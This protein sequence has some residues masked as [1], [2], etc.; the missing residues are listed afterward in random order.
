MELISF[1]KF[2]VVIY[3]DIKEIKYKLLLKLKNISISQAQIV[4]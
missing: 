1:V 2:A 4:C 3:I